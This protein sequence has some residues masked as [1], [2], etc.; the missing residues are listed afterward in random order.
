[1]DIGTQPPVGALWRKSRASNDGACV[2]ITDTA[3]RVWVRDSKD[4]GAGPVLAFTRR[5]WAA[6]LAGVRAGEFDGPA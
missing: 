6:F 4:Q 3:D 5:E 1:V 2:E